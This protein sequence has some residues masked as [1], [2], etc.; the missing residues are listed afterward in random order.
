VREPGTLRVRIFFGAIALLAAIIT[1]SIAVMMSPHGDAVAEGTDHVRSTVVLFMRNSAFG[2]LALCALATWL[3]FPAR[4]PQ[5]QIRE[6]MII[7][8]IAVMVATSLY[9]LVW[10][11]GVA[12]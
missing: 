12:G 4:R 3:L 5:R 6:W 8:L 2:T 10:L 9:Q 11:R 7:I 1:W